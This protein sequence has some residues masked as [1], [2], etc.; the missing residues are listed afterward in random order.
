MTVLTSMPYTGFE[1]ATFGV[2]AGSQKLKRKMLNLKEKQKIM[3]KCDKGE[4]QTV[5]AKEYEIQ[6]RSL[7]TIF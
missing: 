6:Q 2:A 4:K 1:P 5:V 7:S 3:D